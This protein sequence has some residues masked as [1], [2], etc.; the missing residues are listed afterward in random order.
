M[1]MSMGMPMG[2]SMGMLG[3][4]P[5]STAGPNQ[6]TMGSGGEL[7]LPNKVLYLQNLPEG[8]KES[9]LSELF[10]R[11]PGFIEVRMVP[12]RPDVA[13]AEYENEM[14]AMMARQ[15]LDGHEVTAGSPLRVAF[16]KR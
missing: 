5:I 1:G 7:Q 10:K 13:F 4:M 16:A 6:M 11:F 9:Q 14:Q 8:I 15:S 2:V 3:G 12:N